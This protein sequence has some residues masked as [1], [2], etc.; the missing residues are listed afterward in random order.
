MTSESL[1]SNLRRVRG[2]RSDREER[3]IQLGSVE[4]MTLLEW[5]L[6]DRPGAL[7]NVRTKYQQHCVELFQRLE[8]SRWRR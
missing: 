6:K 7:R 3:A 2:S 4:L 1:P 5:E 8:K